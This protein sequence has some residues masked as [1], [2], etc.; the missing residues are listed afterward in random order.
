MKKIVLIRTPIVQPYYHVT[1]LR[2]VPSVGLA[3]VNA[4]LRKNGYD[5]QIIDAPAENISQ[6]KRLENTIFISNG[7]SAEEIVERIP[8]DVDAIGVSCMHTNE[9][10][11]D[12]VIIRKIRE[13]FPKHFLFI[14]GEHATGTAKLILETTP[15][16]DAIVLGEGEQSVLDLLDAHFNQKSFDSILGIAFNKNNK[17]R[18][19]PRRSNI[20]DVNQIAFPDWTGVP[21][22]NYFTF[23]TSISSF[24]KR[25]IPMIATRGC[26]HACTFCTV[27]NM[28]D[29]KWYTRT[30]ENIVEEI[31]IL[32]TNYGI[33]HIDFVDLTMTVSKAWTVEFSQKLIEENLG[34]TW[35]LPIG[36]RTEQ[37][38]FEVLGLMRKAGLK[39]ILFSPESGS[40]ATLF[41]INKKLNMDHMNAAIR[42]S[43]DVGLTVKLATIFGFPGQT[44]KEVFE[45]LVFIW[46]SAF[47][48]VHDVVC[49]SFVPY[50]GTVLYDQVVKE[51]KLEET[52]EKINLNNDIRNMRSWSDHIPSGAMKYISFFGMSSFYGLQFLARPYR[53][54]K[55]INAVFV[56]KEPL[57]NLE[58]MI[59]GKIF[60][61]KALKDR[62]TAKSLGAAYSA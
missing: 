23:N 40:K 26:P 5:S 47:I 22:E 45:S 15:E 57:T 9:W 41:R 2:A 44:K 20:K 59:Y 49:L 36:T 62:A 48:G 39:R 33:Q 54:I 34:I 46:K 25:S 11:Y 24:D 4:S 30:P 56:K 28:W 3:Y 51:G 43:L 18:L 31:K 16:I 42:N 14:G 38:D 19:N 21:L 61:A 53:F 6:F 1:G 37:L 8:K 7:L 52:L 35:S 32:K 55:L 27:P 12:S 29:S 17:P 13:I 50:P 58:C 60:R 10:I